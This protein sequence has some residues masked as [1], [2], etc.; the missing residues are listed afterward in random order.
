MTDITTIKK[1]YRKQYPTQLPKEDYRLYKQWSQ[2][3]YKPNAF[4]EK[5]KLEKQLRTLGYGYLLG[6]LPNKK[7]VSKEA[8]QMIVKYRFLRKIRDKES[9]KPIRNTLREMGLGAFV[10]D[11]PSE[12]KPTLK[13][14]YFTNENI[15]Q[16]SN[17]INSEVLGFIDTEFTT[18]RHEILSIGCVLY[19]TRTHKSYEFYKTA[20]PIYEKKLSIR[21]MELTHLTQEEINESDS[22]NKVVCEFKE[23]L[24][25]HQAGPL[26]VWGNSDQLSMKTSCAYGKVKFS[27]K[28]DILHRFIDIQ[29]I[30]SLLRDE[31]RVQF[32]LQDMKDF[33]KIEGEVE[34]HAL[35][36][37]RD[38]KN[39]MLR[40]IDTYKS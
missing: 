3:K 36:D 27:I 1:S 12:I 39:V 8:Y 31:T 7:A 20:K 28:N 16:F 6:D 29:P 38:L 32:S 11:I 22:F 17:A 35:S 5:K 34:H 18:R 9:I 14:R 24:D 25:Q 15:V 21:C 23:F 2:I 19:D 40:F 30:V 37:A 4:K 33:Y 26:M 10:G 13:E